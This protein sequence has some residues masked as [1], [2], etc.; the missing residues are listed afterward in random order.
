MQMNYLKIPFL[1][2]IS[3]SCDIKYHKNRY[4]ITDIKVRLL[5][6]NGRDSSGCTIV[7]E[8]D[9][10]SGN[11]KLAL[12][13]KFEKEFCSDSSYIPL[14]AMGVEGLNEP[15]QKVKNIYFEVLLNNKEKLI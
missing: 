11:S 7:K 4:K 5:E 10:L 9:T 1:I 14:M 12:A 13:I 6:W 8:V 2:L 3:C 15:L